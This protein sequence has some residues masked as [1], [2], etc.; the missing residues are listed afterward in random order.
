M[1]RKVDLEWDDR[2]VVP[3]VIYP[4][5]AFL[6]DRMEEATLGML[7]LPQGSKVLDVGCGHALDALELARRGQEVVGLEPSRVMLAKARGVIR[8][9]GEEVALVRGVG[10]SLPFRARAFSGVVCKGALDHFYEPERVVAEISRVLSPEGRAVI[11]I[12][13]FESL[14]CRLG[15]QFLFI[16]RL[17]NGDL[18]RPRW[19]PPP[20]HTYKF[21]YPT[22]KEMLG[23]HLIIEKAMGVC[24]LWGIPLWQWVAKLPRP[25]GWGIL[26]SLDRLGRRLPSLADVIVVRCRAR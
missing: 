14:G 2:G 10:A 22:L 5:T 21:N 19:E 18:E 25:V 16:E 3:P 13:N 8:A 23:R 17:F 1:K 11:S 26:R 4:D 20:D 6:F 15:R 9:R 24:L 12:A 7:R